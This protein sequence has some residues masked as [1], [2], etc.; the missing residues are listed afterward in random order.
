MAPFPQNTFFIVVSSS[1]EYAEY[2]GGT[3]T[4]SGLTI[5]IPTGVGFLTL[6]PLTWVDKSESWMPSIVPVGQQA[7][8]TQP[9]TRARCISCVDPCSSGT[10]CKA[11]HTT[12]T[13]STSS[14]SGAWSADSATPV[15]CITSGTARTPVSSVSVA[16]QRSRDGSSSAKDSGSAPVRSSVVS[17]K[18]SFFSVMAFRLTPPQIQGWLR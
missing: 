11:S 9:S 4:F 5:G 16:G 8:N 3:S 12:P 10:S 15:G 13:G 2:L 7:N 17:C 18:L 14:S 6:L 1:N